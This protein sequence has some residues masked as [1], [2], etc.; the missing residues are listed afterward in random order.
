MPLIQIMRD[1]SWSP[2]EEM[3]SWAQL[4]QIP[5]FT[6]FKITV[7]FKIWTYGITDILCLDSNRTLK[8]KD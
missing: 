1:S 7:R 5:L 8:K 6:I 4:S 3:S 2:K